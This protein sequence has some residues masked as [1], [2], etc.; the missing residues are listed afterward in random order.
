MSDAEHLHVIHAGMVHSMSATAIPL[1][2]LDMLITRSPKIKT[3][4]A[5]LFVMW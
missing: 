1:M 5:D 3:S 4:V 2:V